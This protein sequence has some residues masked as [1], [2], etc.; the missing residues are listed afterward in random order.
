MHRPLR[1]QD[2]APHVPA[3]VRTQLHASPGTFTV[4]RRGAYLCAIW[5]S[6]RLVLYHLF[7][8]LCELPAPKYH[9]WAVLSGGAS[10]Q[11]DS[12]A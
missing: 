7:D 4:S 2:Q 8:P 10:P 11:T 6:L 9:R 12:I 1:Q 5:Q 3:L